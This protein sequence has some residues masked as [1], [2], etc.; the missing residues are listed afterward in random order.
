[1]HMLIF[2]AKIVPILPRFVA[3]LPLM[4]LP[5]ASCASSGGV[6][7]E[8]FQLGQV[9]CR[10]TCHHVL[11]RQNTRNSGNVVRG[12]AKSTPNSKTRKNQRLQ[13]RTLLWMGQQRFAFLLKARKRGE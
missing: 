5:L 9:V 13:I 10:R 4:V 11:E 1:M 7:G 6:I 12:A 2:M 3:L 8:E